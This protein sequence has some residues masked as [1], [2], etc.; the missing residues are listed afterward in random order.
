M[1]RSLSMKEQSAPS[2]SL[3][4]VDRA[5]ADTDPPELS[6]A[7]LLT[8][9]A[10]SSSSSKMEGAASRACELSKWIRSAQTG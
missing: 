7:D 9:R 3:S 5:R 2:I 8:P 1:Q 4:S 6:S 10:S